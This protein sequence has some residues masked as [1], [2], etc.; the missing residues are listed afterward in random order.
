MVEILDVKILVPAAVTFHKDGN[1]GHIIVN[2]D[3]ISKKITPPSG[4]GEEFDQKVFEYIAKKTTKA[5][6]PEMPRSGFAI[7]A[8]KSNNSE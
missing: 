1:E 2:L 5:F 8:K 4:Y 6:V 3:Y 7:T